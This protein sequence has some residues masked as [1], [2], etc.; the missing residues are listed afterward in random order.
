MSIDEDLKNLIKEIHALADK[1]ND[2]N[3][4][5]N[6][7]AK[8]MPF[9][10]IFEDLCTSCQDKVNFRVAEAIK[11]DKLLNPHPFLTPI[12]PKDLMRS[13]SYDYE[14]PRVRVSTNSN[15]V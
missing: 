6:T 14:W 7:E 11:K 13:A 3:E 2:T 15:K 5:I 4:T 9:R 12:S 8:N 1:L 10:P